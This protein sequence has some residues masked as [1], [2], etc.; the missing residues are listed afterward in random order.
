V[1]TSGGTHKYPYGDEYG[2]DKCNGS[3]AGNQGTVP[4]K[5]MSGCVTSTEGYAGVFDLVGN[6]REWEDTCSGYQE[7][8]NCRIRGGSYQMAD[9]GSIC[10]I[11]HV[12]YRSN[13]AKDL[14]FRCCAP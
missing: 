4:V 9:S 11:E 13:A 12:D 2:W 5:T 1:C 3:D 8:A 10:T 7:N 6:A 14:G